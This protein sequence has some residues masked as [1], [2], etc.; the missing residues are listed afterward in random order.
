[1]ISGF[2]QTPLTGII[3]EI[4]DQPEDNEILFEVEIALTDAPNFIRAGM[5]VKALLKTASHSGYPIPLNAFYRISGQEGI[6]FMLAQNK[7]EQINA[8]FDFVSGTDAIVT[9][10]LSAF[11][12][13]IVAGQQHLKQGTPVQVIGNN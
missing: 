10:D 1:M 9:T 13:V 6:L 4:A 5:Q 3:D 11:N 2:P 8:Q 7:A 12:A